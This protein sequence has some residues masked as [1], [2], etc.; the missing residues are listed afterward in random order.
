MTIQEQVMQAREKAGLKLVFILPDQE[1]PF[2]VYPKSAAMK[3]QVL[4]AAEQRGW[5]LT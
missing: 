1:E 2:T 3:R 5:K 4:A